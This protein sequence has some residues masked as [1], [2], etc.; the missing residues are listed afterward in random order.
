VYWYWHLWQHI[1]SQLSTLSLVSASMV[2][3]CGTPS[4]RGTLSTSG[5]LPTCG[6]PLIHGSQS[7]ASRLALPLLLHHPVASPLASHHLLTA[8]GQSSTG[9]QPVLPLAEDNDDNKTIL[10]DTEV[11]FSKKSIRYNSSCCFDK[12]MWIEIP[13]KGKS[14]GIQAQL[15]IIRQLLS[16]AI[17]HI[18]YF[19]CFCHAFPNA[20]QTVKFAHEALILAAHDL[21]SHAQQIYEWFEESRLYQQYLSLVVSPLVNSR[22]HI[23]YIIHSIFTAVKCNKNYRKLSYI[24]C[25]FQYTKFYKNFDIVLRFLQRKNFR[26]NLKQNLTFNQDFIQVFHHIKFNVKMLIHNKILF[27]VFKQPKS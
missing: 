24:S 2:S 21:G 27:K 20:A 7:A 11:V 19:I 10:S 13:A 15:E 8:T 26:K 25:L 4:T 17:K 18:A 3:T 23:H 1:Y 14:I 5:T 6:M 22:V 9:C 16:A 12:S